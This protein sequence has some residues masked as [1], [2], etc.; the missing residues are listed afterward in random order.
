MSFDPNIPVGPI[1]PA[2]QVVPL[3]TNFLTYASGFLSNHTALNLNKQGSHEGVLLTLQ[4]TDPGVSQDLAVLYCKN[5]PS[6]AGTQPQLFVQIPAFI[7][8]INPPNPPMQLTYNTVSLTGPQY[9]SFLP[10]GYIFYWGSATITTET[11]IPLNP[12]P[13]N[14]VM[15]IAYAENAFNAVGTSKTSNQTFSIVPFTSSFAH[16]YQYMVIALA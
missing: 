8:G 13:T 12:V 4:T 11:N 5:A 14:I 16:K 2:Q 7:P 9:Q 1:S 15:A 6:N 3:R 10:G